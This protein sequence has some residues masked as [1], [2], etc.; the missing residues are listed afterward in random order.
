[1][2][3]KKNKKLTKQQLFKYQIFN[4]IYYKILPKKI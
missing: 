1:M 3:G 4:L 2:R